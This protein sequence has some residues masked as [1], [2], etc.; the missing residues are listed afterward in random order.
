M[1]RSVF[2][3]TR[4]FKDGGVSKGKFHEQLTWVIVAIGI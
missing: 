1:H 4:V 2:S 3:I